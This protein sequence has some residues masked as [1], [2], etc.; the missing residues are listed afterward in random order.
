MFSSTGA[1]YHRASLEVNRTPLLIIIIISSFVFI[2]T[3]CI[4]VTSF[5]AS[6][7]YQLYGNWVLS[8]KLFK[9]N[10]DTPSLKCLFCLCPCNEMFWYQWF[11]SEKTAPQAPV[12]TPLAAILPHVSCSGS[13]SSSYF[14]LTSPQL[15]SKIRF[16]V[17][18]LLREGQFLLSRV[19]IWLMLIFWC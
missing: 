19:K 2:I 1:R 7:P 12:A 10:L 18:L 13:T 9:I 3:Q 4:F 16:Y 5:N 17:L 8:V 11:S 14:C 15:F 6:G